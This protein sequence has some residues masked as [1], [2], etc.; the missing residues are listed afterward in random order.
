MKSIRQADMKSKNASPVLADPAPLTKSRLGIPTNSMPCLPSTNSVGPSFPDGLFF[1]S[2]QK[3]TKPS[4][5]EDVRASGWLDAMKSSSP[6][7]RDPNKDAKSAKVQGGLDAAYHSW[8]VSSLIKHFAT[9]K[10]Y[11]YD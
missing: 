11:V 4:K 8:T 9:C 7:Y 6:T 1:P 3:R 5:L 10:Y 2:N